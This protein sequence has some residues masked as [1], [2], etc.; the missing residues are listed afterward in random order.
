MWKISLW[1][2]DYIWSHSTANFGRISHLIE[3]SSVGGAPGYNQTPGIYWN[4]ID[5]EQSS[6][7]RTGITTVRFIIVLQNVRCFFFHIAFHIADSWTHIIVLIKQ[8]YILPPVASRF[9]LF[10]LDYHYKVG[11]HD[12]DIHG[13]AYQHILLIIIFA[14]V[15]CF[16]C[17]SKSSID[18]TYI[19][20][21]FT[22]F[23]LK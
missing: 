21:Q 10:M 7:C 2:V 20:Y 14:H 19:E 11:R 18:S 12:I 13:H 23:Q 8:N 6:I 1:S 9:L 5:K 4:I 22:P 17:L 16:K 15:W 3:L